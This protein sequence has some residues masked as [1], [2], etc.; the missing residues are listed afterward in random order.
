MTRPTVLGGGDY[1][2]VCA[3]KTLVWSFFKVYFLS[4]GRKKSLF[5]ATNT[6]KTVCEGKKDCHRLKFLCLSVIE[7]PPDHA[8]LCFS[9][10]VI[11]S[12]L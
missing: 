2:L 6:L 8:A 10:A 11:S 12:N 5:F 7:F 4:S 3:G 9:Q 1:L